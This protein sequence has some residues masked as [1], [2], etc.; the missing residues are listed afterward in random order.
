MKRTVL[1]QAW[2]GEWFVSY[3]DSDGSPLGSSKNEK[4][5]IYVNGQSWPIMAG[6]AEGKRAKT[7]LESVN[8]H[9]NTDNGIKVSWPGY[10]GYDKNIGGIST[11]P[12]GAKENGGVFLHTNPWVI[13][14]ET[15]Q[16]NG[17]RAFQYYQQINPAE[18]DTD[19]YECEPYCYAQNI[20]SDEHPQ[21]GLAR[22]SWL[23]GTAAW[24]YRAVTW[25]ILGVR[26]G[27]DGLVVDPCIPAG[28]KEF[29][30]TRRFRGGIYRITVKNPGG[31][32]KGVKS[33][34]VDGKSVAEGVLPVIPA[35]GKCRV[36]VVMG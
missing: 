16:G 2:D 28:W 4:G 32:E 33:I 25:Y 20:L 27:Y 13:I 36:E 14:S 29:R 11:Y 18:K 10:N 30:V 6:Y 3:F 23:S 34:S 24:T 5:K 17:T 26:P 19:I 31:V 7:A 1:E 15:L 12:P 8:R 21:Y 9:L 35:G 22:N